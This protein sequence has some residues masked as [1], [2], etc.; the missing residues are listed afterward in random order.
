MA[1][2]AALTKAAYEQVTATP[3]TI[4]PG[5]PSWSD[6]NIL[7]GEMKTA[8]LDFEVSYVWAKE[9]GLLAE[10]E[11]DVQY[12]ATTGETYVPQ[13]KP[14]HTDARLTTGPQPTAALVRVY[15]NE[16]DVK[17]EDWA[18]TVGFR[19][20]IGENWRNRL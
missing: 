17:K 8:S 15:Q 6:V 20:G 13:V 11:G 9:Y 4:I 18:T 1:N 19:R 14:A 16:N 12:L 7:V 2:L 3:F 10:I 5:V